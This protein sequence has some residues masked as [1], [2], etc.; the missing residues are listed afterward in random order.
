MPFVFP[1]IGDAAVIAGQTLGRGALWA[2]SS[3]DPRCARGIHN[4]RV[5]AGRR[6]RGRP[7]DEVLLHES[8]CL[9]KDREAAL[10]LACEKVAEGRLI[11]PAESA[12]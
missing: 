6:A 12:P 8:A 3:R 2:G 11:R 1:N 4:S 9:P 5:R 7:Q 10:A